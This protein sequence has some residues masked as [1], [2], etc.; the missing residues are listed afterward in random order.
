MANKNTK[1]FS[2]EILAWSIAI[3]AAPW[4]EW[5]FT[6]KSNDDSFYQ[7]DPTYSENPERIA[8]KSNVK[9]A[10]PYIF[11]SIIDAMIKAK[12]IGSSKETNYEPDPKKDPAY[13][14]LRK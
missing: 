5:V 10:S 13:I 14:D 7:T 4:A 2:K 3:L 11:N 9:L 8:A 12:E 1:T 6:S